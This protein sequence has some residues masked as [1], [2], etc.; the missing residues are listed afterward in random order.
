MQ[1]RKLKWILVLP[2]I[3]ISCIGLSYTIEVLQFFL[4]SGGTSLFDVISN[5]VGGLLGFLCFSLWRS[6]S[7]S[8]AFLT[9]LNIHNEIRYVI[10]INPY[11]HGTYVAGTGQKI[12]APDFLKEYKPDTVI[13]MNPIYHEEIRQDLNSMGLTPEL[14]MT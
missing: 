11:K 5:S 14:I 3:L 1:R 6:G 4:P 2:I 12:V 9:T 7:K 8:V 13:V 10:D